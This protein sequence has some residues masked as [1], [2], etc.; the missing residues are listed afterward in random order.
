MIMF[1]VRSSIS[2]SV[3]VSHYGTATDKNRRDYLPA[4]LMKSSSFQPSKQLNKVL[5][6]KG[7]RD[8]RTEASDFQ[9]S[10]FDVCTFPFDEKLES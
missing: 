9:G 2:S 10:Q 6:K 4:G 5:N 8:K 3:K 1:H 7:L